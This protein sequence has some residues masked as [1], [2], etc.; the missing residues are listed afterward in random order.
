MKI[1]SRLKK[2]FKESS[3]RWIKRQLNDPFVF[4]AKQKGYRSRASFKIIEIQKKFETF[5][6][7]QLVID[8]GAAPGGWSQ[9]VSRYGCNIIA[10]DLLKMDDLPNV[11]FIQGDFLSEEVLTKIDNLAASTGADV[12]MSDMAPPVCGI[13]KIDY[14]RISLLAESVFEFTKTNL[15]ENGTMIIKV[16]QGGTKTQLLAEIKQRFRKIVHFK[17]KASRKESS[18]IYLVATGFQK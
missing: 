18:E 7:N 9:I 5:Q 16:F 4:S 10:V 1:D 13:K 17:P 11:S 12:I 15:K 2:N 3:K 8:L 14:L 6:K